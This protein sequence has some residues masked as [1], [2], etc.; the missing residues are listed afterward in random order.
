MPTDHIENILDIF[1]QIFLSQLY[2]CQCID[3]LQKTVITH[4]LVVSSGGAS[5]LCLHSPMVAKRIVRLQINLI[6]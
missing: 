2:D 1:L 4:N 3:N 6:A 5:Q